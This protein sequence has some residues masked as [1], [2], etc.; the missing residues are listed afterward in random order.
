MTRNRRLLTFVVVSLLA[1]LS[2]SVVYANS[3]ER[4]TDNAATAGAGGGL[5]TYNRG[6]GC[7]VGICYV[8]GGGTNNTST[9]PSNQLY[10]YTVAT[11][12]WT[13]LDTSP[14]RPL[15][16]EDSQGF[17][18]GHYI[19]FAAGIGNSPTAVT[20]YS[21]NVTADTWETTTAVPTLFTAGFGYTATAVDG[22][23]YLFGPSGTGSGRIAVDDLAGG[24]TT[25][26]GPILLPGSCN[27]LQ[28]S[29]N[30]YDPVNN[31]IV[32]FKRDCAAVYS[33]S[34]NS[35]TY[36]A[37]NALPV[38]NGTVFLTYY[39]ADLG[40]VFGY[41]DQPNSQIDFYVLDTDTFDY[42]VAYTLTDA[43][44][45]YGPFDQGSSN[46]TIPH[47]EYLNAN[48]ES[49]VLFGSMRTGLITPTPAAP[50]WWVFTGDPGGVV[51]VDRNID[52][53]LDNFLTG[54]NMNSPVGRM[55]VGTF[56][57]MALFIVLMLMKV[58]ALIGLGVAGLSGTFLT[59]ALV[60]SPVI[61][62]GAVAI[63]GLGT[64]GLIFSKFLGG[65]GDG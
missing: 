21:Y 55:L 63:L 7:D 52:T 17:T 57:A 38:D 10:R 34:G 56:F 58:P 53:W 32:V 43:D 19:G 6:I 22:S 36:S 9:G 28:A 31:E 37:E 18:D 60:F 45:D 47:G 16:R 46:P 65:D 1:I 12:T 8:H 41:W 39:D 35:W 3:F 51:T 13:L 20:T 42:S 27:N 24:W 54:L 40:V 62:L 59:A 48:N 26:N 64:I 49:I 2:Y 23:F 44:F 30:T 4:V 61:L 50:R 25:R 11:D 29:T 5:G 14:T 33:I 15:Y